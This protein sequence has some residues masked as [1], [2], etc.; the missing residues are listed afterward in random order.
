MIASRLSAPLL[1]AVLTTSAWG[2]KLPAAAAGSQRDCNAQQQLSRRSLLQYTAAAQLAGS[3]LGALA[4]SFDP[5]RYGDKELKLATVERVLQAIRDE[6]GKDLTLLVPLLQLS[7]MDAFSYDGEQGGIDG[8][9]MYELDR[10]SSKGLERAA[11]AVKRVHADMK[12]TTEIT[13]ADVVA[14]AGASAIEAVGGPK[15]KVQLGRDDVKKPGPEGARAGFSW[16]APTLPALKQMGQG[17]KLTGPELVA[18]VGSLGLLE[19]AARPV[20]LGLPVEDEDADIDPDGKAAAA[21]IGGES[22]Y[23]RYGNV[24][25]EAP[26]PTDANYLAASKLSVDVRVQKIGS[27]P[28]DTTYFAQLLDKKRQA[29]LSPLE[30]ALLADGELR[31]SVEEFAKSKRK[32][33]ETVRSTYGRLQVLGGD[34]KGAASFLDDTSDNV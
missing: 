28:F 30:S 8:S 23:T 19:M 24:R 21:S 1:A 11:E 5:D 29:P 14:F 2:L 25:K 9:I 22:S 13:Y 34:F 20:E 15:V 26:K 32:F 18:L 33:R 7:L 10:P 6:C 4:I 17:A 31:K 3:P 27:Q 12:R 16:D